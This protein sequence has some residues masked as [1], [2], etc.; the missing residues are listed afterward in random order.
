MLGARC[1]VVRLYLDDSIFILACCLLEYS[2]Y[3]CN[4]STT[5]CLSLLFFFLNKALL[6]YWTAFKVYT[7]PTVREAIEM[8]LE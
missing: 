3:L 1:V 2:V 8:E 6:N 4:I 5:M 7:L